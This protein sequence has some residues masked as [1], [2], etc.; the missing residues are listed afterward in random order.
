MKL[1]GTRQLNGSR[2]EVWAKLNDPEVL[3]R[4]IP[5]CESLEMVSPTELKATVAL[6]IGP[7]NARFKGDVNL[8]NLNPPES[9]RIEGSGSG[10]VAGRASGGADV[11]LD[12]IDGG[13]ELSY[14]VDATVSGKIA[15]LGQRLIDATAVQLSNKFFDA[16]AREFEPTDAPDVAGDA[17]AAGGHPAS[18]AA[19]AAT[20]GVTTKAQT[21]AGG[22]GGGAASTSGGG[23]RSVRAQKSNVLWYSAGAI[24]LALILAIVVLSF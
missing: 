16:F 5:G 15:Q 6:K 23:S 9:Y 1:N 24:A 3:Q 7:M 12:E 20:A 10:G 18:A 13:T 14:D 11:R 21:S 19:A 17:D 8:T 2:E 4:C 22:P